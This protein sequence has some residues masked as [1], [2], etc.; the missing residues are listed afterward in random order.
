MNW[1]AFRNWFQRLLDAG[2]NIAT[3]GIPPLGILYHVTNIPLGSVALAS[4]ATD[5]AA[6]AG[7]VY[8]SEHW[9]PANQTVTTIGILNGTT[10]GTDKVIYALATDDGTVVA[11]TVLAGTTGAGS[12][13]FQEIAL[14]TPYAAKG[15]GRYWLLYQCNGTTHATQR[16]AANTYHN[17]AGSVAGVFGTIPASI[18][19]PTTV[20]AGAGPIGYTA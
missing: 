12:D 10:V 6:V 16:I 18:T 20:T 5:A 17:R 13:S 2:I 14:T 9:I 4:I 8:Y 11:T 3:G 7:T 19:P 15:P 1:G